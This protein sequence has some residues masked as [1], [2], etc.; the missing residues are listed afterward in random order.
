VRSS[1]KA[2]EAAALIADGASVTIGGFVAVGCVARVVAAT[3]ASLLIPGEVPEM[4]LDASVA[5]M[6]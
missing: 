3:D 2:A 5:P 4:P 6:A 1:I